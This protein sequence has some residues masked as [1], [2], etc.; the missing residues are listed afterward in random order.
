MANQA[1]PGGDL[2]AVK[3]R[4]S[5]RVPVGIILAVL[6]VVTS[7]IAW[8]IWPRHLPLVNDT[9][10]VAKL[11]TRSD[12]PTL[13][14]AKRREYVRAL[15]KNSDVLASALSS[16][17]LS[18]AEYDTAASYAWLERQLDHMEQYF[19][20]PAGPAREK[21]VAELVEKSRKSGPS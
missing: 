8:K 3:T 20:L 5:R 17:K 19:E 7:A 10:A 9:V 12:F 16:G 18:Q 14:E 2:A 1:G 15:R 4:A 13:P 6:V 11:S 21:Y